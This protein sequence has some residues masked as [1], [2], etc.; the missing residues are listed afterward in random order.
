MARPTN[1]QGFRPITVDNIRYLWRC[2]DHNRTADIEVQLAS[3]SSARRQRLCANLKCERPQRIITS[4]IVSAIILAAIADGW[5]PNDVAL[6]Y[7]TDIV[8]VGPE[9]QVALNRCL[10]IQ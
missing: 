4:R 8:R 5:R 2:G 6:D 7:C 3:T 10:M 1:K 9:G